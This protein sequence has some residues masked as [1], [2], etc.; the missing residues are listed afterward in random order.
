[1]WLLPVYIMANVIVLIAPIAA[2]RGFFGS[3]AVFLLDILRR[4]CNQADLVHCLPFRKLATG[5]R[6]A[7]RF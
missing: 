6:F 3:D 7:L 2:T 4:T 5:W 1:M